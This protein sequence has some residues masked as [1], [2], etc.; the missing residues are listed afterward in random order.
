MAPLARSAVVKSSRRSV[1]T[2]TREKDGRGFG[3]T[4]ANATT[5]THC[6]RLQPMSRIPIIGPIAA[7]LESAPLHKASAFPLDY[8][9]R[10]LASEVYGTDVPTVAQLSAVRRA[11]ARL[12][13]TG[14]AERLPERDPARGSTGYH[15]RRRVIKRGMEVSH[16]HRY[17]NPGGV[18]VRRVL[19]DADREARAAAVKG[20]TNLNS[21]EQIVTRGRSRAWP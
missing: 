16:T 20:F 15:F 5:G 13:A 4:T 8:D 21:L 12:V 2:L 14:R 17:A 7:M 9:H 18:R 19:T 6:S 11:T 10:A 1:V 3:G